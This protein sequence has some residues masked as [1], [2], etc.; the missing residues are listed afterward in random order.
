MAAAAAAGLRLQADVAPVGPA[1]SLVLAF[2]LYL[3][4]ER[5]ERR[6]KTLEL[7]EKQLTDPI[8]RGSIHAVRLA[9]AEGSYR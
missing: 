3:S 9:V 1:L 2:T 8:L 7:Y 4:R 6:R 5:S